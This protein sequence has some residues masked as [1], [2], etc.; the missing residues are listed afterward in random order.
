M[1]KQE[2]L[3]QNKVNSGLASTSA[4]CPQQSLGA[5]SCVI[6]KGFMFRGKDRWINLNLKTRRALREKGV[7]GRKGFNETA[8]RV[9]REKFRK[10]CAR[11]ENL[12]G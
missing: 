10:L 5:T 2:G 7:E 11:W 6:N 12:K 3:Y 8:D 9:T 4:W 1:M